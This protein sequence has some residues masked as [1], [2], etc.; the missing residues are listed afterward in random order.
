M[1][2][3]RT[4]RIGGK[5]WRR[6]M[7][8]L[9]RRRNVE[10]TKRILMRVSGL[11]SLGEQRTLQLRPDHGRC[12]VFV[13]CGCIQASE[14]GGVEAIVSAVLPQLGAIGV[15]RGNAEEGEQ[16][17]CE[18]ELNEDKNIVTPDVGPVSS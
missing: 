7:I 11:V 18:A 9:T 6:Y 3:R 2:W 17:D 13:I 14:R 10:R 16:G 1:A 4:E 12:V 8:D 15:W 5:T